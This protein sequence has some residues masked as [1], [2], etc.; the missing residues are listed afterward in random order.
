MLMMMMLMQHENYDLF[1][2]CCVMLLVVSLLK[3]PVTR[4]KTI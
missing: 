2:D 4:S 3:P 1:A